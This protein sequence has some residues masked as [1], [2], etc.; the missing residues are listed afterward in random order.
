MPRLL[1]SAYVRTMWRTLVE[2]LA[3]ILSSKCSG[4]SVS[5]TT[6]RR[7]RYDG[8]GNFRL[9]SMETMSKVFYEDLVYFMYFVCLY[10]LDDPFGVFLVSLPLSHG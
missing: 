10:I 1:R 2:R 3:T 7:K 5:G 6:S 9:S 4:T 8:H